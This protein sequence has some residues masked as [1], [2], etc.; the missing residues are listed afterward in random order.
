MSVDDIKNAIFLYDKKM[1]DFYNVSLERFLQFV[2][3]NFGPSKPLFLESG[4]VVVHRTMEPQGIDSQA[5]F[6]RFTFK[7]KETW[8]LQMKLWN[9]KT[10]KV[11]DNLGKAYPYLWNQ[12]TLPLKNCL[13][14]HQKYKVAK[15]DN[16]AVQL[17]MMIE[18]T[19]TSTLIVI[20][21]QKRMLKA[22]LHLKSVYGEN[23]EL[24]KYY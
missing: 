12:C 5:A 11:M 24:A 19:C 21:V 6:N 1:S 8:K 22:D 16:D 3:S 9:S 10:E 7:E 23:M 20:S 15:K 18:E 17:W 14:T 4:Q 2:G 13:K